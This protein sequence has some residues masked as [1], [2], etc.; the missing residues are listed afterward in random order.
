MVNVVVEILYFV[1]SGGAS[2]IE[3]GDSHMQTH[4]GEERDQ[5][6]VES[7]T[8]RSNADMNKESSDTSMVDDCIVPGKFVKHCSER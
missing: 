7:V 1:F 3:G 2:R 6:T 5:M 4:I 8:A